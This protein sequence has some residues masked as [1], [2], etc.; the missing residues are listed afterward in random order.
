MASEICNIIKTTLTV[1]EYLEDIV[2]DEFNCAVFE[3]KLSDNSTHCNSYRW[4]K[5]GKCIEHQPRIQIS[6]NGIW[7]RLEITLVTVED[8]GV[9]SII[10]KNDLCKVFSCANLYVKAVKDGS[11]S[12]NEIQCI[13]PSWDNLP[14]QKH[15]LNTKVL[16]GT[17]IELEFI[18]KEDV[19]E[20]CLWYKGSKL[21]QQDDR[22]IILSDSKT[23]TLSIL[24]SQETDTGIYYVVSKT[25]HGILSSLATVVVMDVDLS[26]LNSC[27]TTPYI[28]DPLPDEIETNEGEEI[29]L[30]CKALYSTDTVIEWSKNETPV[31]NNENILVENCNNYYVCLRILKP[32]FADTG[33]YSVQMH[34]EITGQQDSCSCFL[35]VNSK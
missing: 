6:S 15:L 33:E 17:T 31:E 10:I 3:C 21:L 24:Y 23:S 7:H 1:E 19:I 34:N 14:V 8:E 11:L 13:S 30:V 12:N 5:D 28:V 29:R 22:I 35:T 27:E 20:N 9:Y 18:L 2:T 25:K 26:T 16:V 4:Y 32:S